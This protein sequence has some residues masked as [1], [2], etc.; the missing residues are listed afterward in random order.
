M[1]QALS[2]VSEDP[3]RVCIQKLAF[4]VLS[5]QKIPLKGC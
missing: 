4:V 3:Y 1:E 5:L 2:L